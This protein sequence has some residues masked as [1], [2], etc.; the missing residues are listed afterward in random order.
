MRFGERLLVAQAADPADQTFDLHASRLGISRLI[1]DWE[2]AV[3]TT[4]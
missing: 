2:T 3:D 1:R 4:L